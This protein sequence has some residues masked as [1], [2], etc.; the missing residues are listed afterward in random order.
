M[1]I[2]QY[3]LLLHHLILPQR[4]IRPILTFI[5][6]RAALQTNQ[7]MPPVTFHIQHPRF[8]IRIQ[9]YPLRL[10][11]SPSISPPFPSCHDADAQASPSP[12][13]AHSAS[14]GSSPPGYC[15]SHNSASAEDSLS[16]GPINIILCSE[17]N[18]K[19]RP[20]QSGKRTSRYPTER[21]SHVFR[22][23]SLSSLKN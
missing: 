1:P 13:P 22:N 11:A 7:R 17:D 14:A 23:P 12:A 10:I 16:P 15:A 4:P 3:P 19:F 6:H 2:N 8:A 20:P 21:F 9:R 5:Q 18:L